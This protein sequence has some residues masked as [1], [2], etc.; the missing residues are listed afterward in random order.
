MKM[1]EDAEVAYATARAHLQV[2]AKCRK[3]N[4]DIA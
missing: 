1:R 4:Y 2:A 3:A